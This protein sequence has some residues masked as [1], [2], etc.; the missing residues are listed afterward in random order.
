MM[1]SF[2]LHVRH[3]GVCFACRRGC[4]NCTV[5]LQKKTWLL[6]VQAEGLLAAVR[7]VTDSIETVLVLRAGLPEYEHLYE[8]CFFGARGVVPKRAS[9][10]RGAPPWCALASPN[11]AH[12]PCASKATHPRPYLTVY[13][14]VL[15]LSMHGHRYSYIRVVLPYYYGWLLVLLPP[16]DYS[17]RFNTGPCLT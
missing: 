7:V 11:R 3:S 9:P 17:G 2:S 4:G 15:V 1:P 13:V 14:H 6:G 12:S 16:G 5:C 8:T 10:R